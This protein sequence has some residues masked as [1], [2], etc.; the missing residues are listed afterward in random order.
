M[1]KSARP[2]PFLMAT[3]HECDDRYREN[4]KEAFNPRYTTHRRHYSTTA[5]FVSIPNIRPAP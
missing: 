2:S 3:V 4:L 1:L 5:R